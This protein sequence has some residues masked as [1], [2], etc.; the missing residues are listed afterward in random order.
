MQ[1]QENRFGDNAYKATIINRVFLFRQSIAFKYLVILQ[2][3]KK[4][5]EISLATAASK[6]KQNIEINKNQKNNKTNKNFKNMK[7][8]F[9][10]ELLVFPF[11]RVIL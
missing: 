1:D 4:T 8:M 7:R 6:A 5:E 10:G 9:S 2:N 11:L 3:A